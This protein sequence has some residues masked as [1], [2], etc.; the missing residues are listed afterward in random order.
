MRLE[1][2][3]I[4]TEEFGS[5]ADSLDTDLR[6][7]SMSVWEALAVWEEELIAKPS[8]LAVFSVGVDPTRPETE[9]SAAS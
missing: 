9:I 6:P 2:F 1:A 7:P 8:I 3:D 4:A 5:R